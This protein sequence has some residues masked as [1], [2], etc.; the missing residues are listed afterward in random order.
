MTVSVPHGRV[1]PVCDQSSPAASPTPDTAQRSA[2]GVCPLD[3]RKSVKKISFILPVVRLWC[4]F[5]RDHA[6]A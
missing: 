5:Q 2:P 1:S 6:C 4:D 3:F